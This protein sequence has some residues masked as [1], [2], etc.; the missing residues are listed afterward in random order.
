MTRRPRLPRDDGSAAL[1]TAIVAPA[2]IL[3][4]V[5]A[6]IG[7]RVEVA[8]GSIEQA[9]HDAA[10]AA[11]LE[12]T[13]GQANAAA[14]ATARS[15]LRRQGLNCSPVVAVDTSGF[16][17]PAGQV[18]TV[19]VTISCTVRFSDVTAPGM[20][21]SRKITTSFVSVIDAYRART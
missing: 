7:M 8:G 6:V 18:G 16:A 9:A 15:S 10:R 20:P 2:L 14:L 13:S 4:L 11:S 21:G 12:R 5:L 19:R 1:E 3:L 17:V